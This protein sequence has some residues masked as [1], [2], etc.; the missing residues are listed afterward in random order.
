MLCFGFAGGLPW[1]LSG[2]TLRQWMSEGHVT[3]VLI[4]LTASVG[5]SYSFKFLW[6]PALDRPAPGPFRR[7][8]RRRGWLLLVQPALIATTVALS[9]SD[10]V[11]HIGVTLGIAALI[12]FL[13]AT[14]DIAIDAWRIES[15]GTG[16]QGIALAAYIWGYRIAIL[17]GGA[18]VI[19]LA[20]PLGW[21]RAL[22][23]AAAA[24]LV[25]LIATLLATEPRDVI[26]RPRT[27]G[28]LAGL[29]AAFGHP[30]REFLTRPGAPAIIAYVALF[31]LGEVMANVML[32]PFYRSL[33]FDRNAVALASGPASLAALIAGYAAGSW[34]IGRI[35]LG[36]A[37]IVTGFVQM[38]VIGMYLLLAVSAGN[39]AMLI[40]TAAVESFA[41]GLADAAFLTFLSALCAPAYTA[42]QYALL[43]SLAT[44]P[45][46]TMGGVAGKLAAALGW[47]PFF[48]VCV[49]GGLPAM[50]VMVWILKAR[51]GALPPTLPIGDPAGDRGPQTPF[52]R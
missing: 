23:A 27:P 25:G 7:F 29:A 47:M 41:E 43:S 42:T 15:F 39:H 6:S 13:S 44:I 4:G 3:L 34:I 22:L 1:P 18:G 46:R 48:G 24:G 14:Q 50:A 51:P 31:K 11:R 2:L 33:G 45:L 16:E 49:L 19:A 26:D 36:R 8:G 38:A 32:T 12:A 30:L 9:L 37:L 35:G 28:L 17:A 21:H 40:G 10:P 52:H 20:T 5:L